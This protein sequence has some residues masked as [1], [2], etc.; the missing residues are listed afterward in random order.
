MRRKI[1]IIFMITGIVMLI[2]ALS[3]FAYNRYENNKASE[4]SKSVLSGFK[5]A[6][7]EE[8]NAPIDIQTAFGRYDCIGCIVIPSLDLELP[9]LSQWSY[10]NLQVAP[11]RYSGS[12]QMDDLVI[13]AHN[14]TCHFGRLDNLKPSDTVYFVDTTGNMSTYEVCEINVL[15]PTAIDDMTSGEYDLTLFTC[16]YGG[17]SRTTVRCNKVNKV[18]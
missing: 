15:A 3:L 18:T 16:T 5:A 7:Q 1:G 9:V 8:D 11:C 12:P 14:Y 17:K 13:A 4:A 2:A 6:L 10:P